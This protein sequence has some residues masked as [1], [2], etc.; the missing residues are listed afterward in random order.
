MRRYIY[1]AAAVTL[2]V[3]IF[4]FGS[5]NEWFSI[6]GSNGSVNSVTEATE[7]RYK[8]ME[9]REY[10]GVR[11]DPSVGPRDNSISG[12]QKVD[13]NDYQLKVTGLVNNP[14]A[15][16]YDQVLEKESSERLI[17]L[18]CVE[19]W[20]ASVLWKG[21]RIM[22]LMADAGVRE[23]AKV[24]IFHCVDGYTTSIPLETIQKK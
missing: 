10:N 21:V 1:F 12:I 22:D 17:T 5:I 23:E 4:Y 14:V 15:F 18:Y 24:V 11:L 3:L 6:T 7:N 8:E 20:N 19:G 9:I 2:I 16:S 13:V